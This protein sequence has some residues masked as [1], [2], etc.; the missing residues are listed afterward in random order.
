MADTNPDHIVEVCR[1]AVEDARLGT[2]PRFTIA[3][4]QAALTDA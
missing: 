4:A 1:R 2:D 3:R